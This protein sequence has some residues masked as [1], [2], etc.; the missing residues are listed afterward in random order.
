VAVLTRHR[1]AFAISSVAGEAE[2]L[3]DDFSAV[4]GFGEFGTEEFVD[5]F[6]FGC[7]DIVFI[8]LLKSYDDGVVRMISEEGI[9]DGNKGVIVCSRCADGVHCLQ[10]HLGVFVEMDR[11]HEGLNDFLIPAGHEGLGDANR[12]HA[13]EGAGVG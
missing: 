11:V 1:S 3:V 13:D 12:G 4:H 8:E 9:A 10:I 2:L 7:A 6:L 5:A